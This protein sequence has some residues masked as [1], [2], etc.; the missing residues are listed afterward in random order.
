MWKVYFFVP[1]LID[2]V[3]LVLNLAAFYFILSKPFLTVALHF[4]GGIVLDV[5]D[6]IFARYLNQCSRYGALL[7]GVLDRCGRVGM[8]M[9]LCVFY[10]QYLFVLQLLVCLT[11]AVGVSIHYR[12]FL[13][14]NP[15]NP[16]DIYSVSQSYD[17][18]LVKIYFEEPFL[19]LVLVGQDLFVAMLY[20]LH[21]SPGPSVSFAGS[22]YSLWLLLAWIGA[23]FFIYRQVIVHGLLVFNSFRYLARLHDQENSKKAE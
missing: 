7:D 23:P 14:A 1:N 9:A 6:G 11:I 4:T 21:F 10:P 20:L 12:R 3:R 17:H 13:V 18:W 22:S 16:G 5:L 2:Y 19:T 15:V 8:M